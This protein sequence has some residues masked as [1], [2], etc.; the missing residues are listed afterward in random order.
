M[1]RIFSPR[2]VCFQVL[3]L[4]LAVLLV[5]TAVTLAILFSHGEAFAEN[6][7]KTALILSAMSA[8]MVAAIA[9]FVAYVRFHHPR[10][11]SE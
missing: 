3:A 7:D 6:A 8:V 1:K 4:L 10:G 2:A 11:L 5:L 9:A